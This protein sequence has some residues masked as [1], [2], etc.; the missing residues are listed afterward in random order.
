M[1]RADSEINVAGRIRVML[2]LFG[3]SQFSSLYEL[4]HEASPPALVALADST[5]D[6]A[7]LRHNTEPAT[8]VVLGW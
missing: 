1:L 5:G 8:R 4:S 2:T 6:M 3:R 7:G